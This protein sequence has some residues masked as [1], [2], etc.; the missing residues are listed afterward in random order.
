MTAPVLQTLSD[1]IR[2]LD[3]AAAALEA[4][5]PSEELLQAVVARGAF[6]P[7]ENES[8]GFWFARNLSVREELWDVINE[9]LAEIGP[10]PK[11]IQNDDDLKLFLV[12]Y[13][14]VCLLVRIDRLLLFRVATH[15]LVQRKLNEAFP[16]YRIP[17]KQ[18]TQIFSA[19]VH[20]RNALALLSAMRYV[21]KNRGSIERLQAEPDVGFIVSR[22]D[23]YESALDPSKR[24][25]L[26][27]AWSYVMHKWRRRGVVS[28]SNVFAGV[29]ESAGRTAS[30]FVDKSNKKVDEAIR[31]EIVAFLQPGDVLITRHARA[32]TNLFLPG[33]WP[34]AVLYIGLPEE[35]DAAGIEVEAERAGRWTN[36]VCFL[37]ARKDGVRL[38]PPDDSL[39]VDM[40]V[41]L[42]PTLDAAG[43]RRAIERALVHEGK[44]YNFDF[45]FFNSD[46]LVCTELVYRAY[47][48]LGDLQFPLAERAGRKTLSAEDVID[49]SLDTACFEPV[50]IFGVPGADG[51]VRYGETVRDI[52]LATYRTAN[53]RVS[54][55]VQ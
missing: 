55:G 53:H 8:V 15:S 3:E 30:V 7:D 18:Y 4:D 40:F 37:E 42:R 17:R 22:L 46:R 39:A 38:R 32:L 27:L 48:G 31:R 25:Y 23:A 52:L 21:K 54:T 24:N 34:H 41:V 47:D 5:A 49:F 44:L 43:I 35:R 29:M 14:A 28:A 19:F 10:S 36:D 33:F 50:A 20:E 13:A 51:A 12:G 26:K 45:D 6:R 11:T 9:V 16:E 1:S 2:S